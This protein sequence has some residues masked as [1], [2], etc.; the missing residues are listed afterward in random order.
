MGCQE[1]TLTDLKF[2]VY[3]LAYKEKNDRLVLSDIK[4]HFNS[5]ILVLWKVLSLP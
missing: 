2:H 4:E 3:E 5:K 1:W